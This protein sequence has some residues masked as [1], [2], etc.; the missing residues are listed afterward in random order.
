MGTAGAATVAGSASAEKTF[1]PSAATPN[2]PLSRDRSRS[3]KNR[4]ARRNRS[5][6]VDPESW[7]EVCKDVG[8]GGF[9]PQNEP[10]TSHHP[11]QAF[12]NEHP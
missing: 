7:N 9:L 3:N 10:Q 5:R 1:S 8:P 12:I 11:P 4:Y 2:P 6:Y